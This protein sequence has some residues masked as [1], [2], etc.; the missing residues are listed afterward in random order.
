MFNKYKPL[1]SLRHGVFDIIFCVVMKSVLPMQ[2]KIK[3]LRYGISVTGFKQA[4]PILTAVV[5]IQ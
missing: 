5:D 3:P 1:R 2:D 4:V